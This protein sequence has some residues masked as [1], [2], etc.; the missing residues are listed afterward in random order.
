MVQAD[1]VIPTDG[2]SSTIRRVMVADSDGI[3]VLE[4]V[5][6]S[7]IAGGSV[8]INGD[9][10]PRNTCRIVYY[11]IVASASTDFDLEVYPTDGFTANTFL[12]QEIDNNLIMKSQPPDNGDFYVDRDE[13]KE[14]HIKIVNTDAVNASTFTYKIYYKA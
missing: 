1:S 13:S 8:T 2:Y 5:T 4:G 11:D 3:Q 9:I 14:M 7:V 6:A 12:V 10:S